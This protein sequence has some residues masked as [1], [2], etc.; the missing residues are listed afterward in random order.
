MEA[1]ARSVIHSRTAP[2]FASSVVYATISQPRG[3]SGARSAAKTAE[4]ASA[5]K[6]HA[7]GVLYA[8]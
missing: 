1:R 3:F 6:G 8:I 4:Y 5:P 2:G 7:G